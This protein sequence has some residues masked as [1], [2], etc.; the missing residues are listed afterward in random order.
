MADLCAVRYTAAASILLRAKCAPGF[1]ITFL[2]G[3]KL[4][5]RIIIEAGLFYPTMSDFEFSI[6][7]IT[8]YL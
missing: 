7:V 2:H 5:T 4:S 3:K 6:E 8:N 1:T